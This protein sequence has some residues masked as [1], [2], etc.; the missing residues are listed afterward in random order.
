MELIMKKYFINK[1]LEFIP[2]DES[3]QVVHDSESG[4][5]HYVDEISSVILDLLSY[6]MTSD[7]LINKLLDMYEG[8]PDEIRADT[9]E[10][11]EE[12]VEKNI[13]TEIE[14]EN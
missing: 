6:P 2:L 4:D 12:L 10:F 8:D 7:E 14:D 11:L 5:I 13:I 1:S 9:L 3:E